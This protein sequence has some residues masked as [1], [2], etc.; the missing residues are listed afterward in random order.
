MNIRIFLLV[1]FLVGACEAIA[2]EIDLG[3]GV[4]VEV[5]GYVGGRTSFNGLMCGNV[6]EGD[7]SI[8]VCFSGKMLRDSAG[9]GGFKQYRD[10]SIAEKQRVE[11][12]S[13][14]TY[15]YAEGGYSWLYPT[16]HRQLGELDVHE[17]DNVLCRDDSSELGKPARCYAA[18]LESH[19]GKKRP[20]SIYVDAIIEKPPVPGN[21]NGVSTR[22]RIEAIHVIVKSIKIRVESKKDKCANGDRCGYRTPWS[23]DLLLCQEA[24]GRIV[25]STHL[26]R[27][28][29]ADGMGAG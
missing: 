27:G 7:F 28:Q 6:D 13:N 10:L 11:E 21:K 3:S 5:P 12:L 19:V 23:A 9:D 15:V 25:R 14:E 26:L 22:R 20:L 18:A 4:A 2:S 8:V 1:Y 16:T 17:V 29:D 24:D